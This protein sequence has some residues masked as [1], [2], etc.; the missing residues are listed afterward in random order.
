MDERDAIT[1]LFNFNGELFLFTVIFE[2]GE[3]N[4]V[5]DEA[6][7]IV[8]GLETLDDAVEYL[9]DTYYHDQRMYHNGV[10]CSLTEIAET[11][12]SEY[13]AKQ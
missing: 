5:W 4:S 8:E 12:K 13:E 7:D 3:F 11:F 6:N 9:G 2:E 1:G 10:G